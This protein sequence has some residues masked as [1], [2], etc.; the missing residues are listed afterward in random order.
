MSPDSVDRCRP[1]VDALRSYDTPITLLSH[2]MPAVLVLTVSG[3]P[4]LSK[5]G[6]GGGPALALL[7][8][9]VRIIGCYRGLHPRTEASTRGFV[10]T[11]D[12]TGRGL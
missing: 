4:Y 7:C 2:V 3:R 1:T 12:T 9:F 5:L 10:Q 6:P 11:P 8:K